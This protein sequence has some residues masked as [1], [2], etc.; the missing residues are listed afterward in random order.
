MA[1]GVPVVTSNTTSLPEVVG[2]AGIT[3]PPTDIKA[4]QDALWRVLSDSALREAM[5]RSGAARARQF[6]WEAAARETL[7]IYRNVVYAEQIN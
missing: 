7:A 6:S 2:E 1:C 5:C 3:L 4:V